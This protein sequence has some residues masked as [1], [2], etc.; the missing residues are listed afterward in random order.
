V[1]YLTRS[2]ITD[3]VTLGT[4]DYQIVTCDPATGITVLYGIAQNS[5]KGLSVA[6]RSLGQPF[7]YPSEIFGGESQ[8]GKLCSDS[9]GM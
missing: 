8:G 1:L 3:C 9:F 5:E 7:G 6:L 4:V 2:G